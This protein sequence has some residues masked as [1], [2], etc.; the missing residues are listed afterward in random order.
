MKWTP[1][2][3]DETGKDTKKKEIKGSHLLGEVRLYP[4]NR[5][6]GLTLGKKKD[7]SNYAVFSNKIEEK[8]QIVIYDYSVKKIGEYDLEG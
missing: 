8:T 4:F 3:K 6:L 7:S 2:E 5:I 1:F